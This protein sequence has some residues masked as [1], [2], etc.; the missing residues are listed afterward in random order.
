MNKSILISSAVGLA[1]AVSAIALNPGASEPKSGLAVGELVSAFH[2]SHVTGPLAGTDSCP[3]CTYGN[4]PMVQAW[5]N[6]DTTQNIAAIAAKLDKAMV[7]K[8]GAELKTFVIVLTSDP[9]STSEELKAIAKEQGLKNVALAYLDKKDS[10][11]EDYKMSVSPEVKNTIFVYRN[12]KVD[13]KFVNLDPNEAGLTSLS[14]AIDKIT[15]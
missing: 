5:I 3:P 7:A 2:P 1:L 10:A 14:L 13:S 11:V 6:G 12:R 8:S 9:K 15:K 4:L